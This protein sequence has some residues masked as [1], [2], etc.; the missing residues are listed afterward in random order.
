M[1]DQQPTVVA[2]RLGQVDRL[3]GGDRLLCGAADHVRPASLWATRY[4]RNRPDRHLRG[5]SQTADHSDR[6][7]L[8]TVTTSG[9]TAAILRNPTIGASP[10]ERITSGGLMMNQ[11]LAAASLISVFFALAQTGQE[12]AGLVGMASTVVCQT[13]IDVSNHMRMRNRR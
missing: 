6:H 12:A 5:S 11:R 1:H 13:A 8:R 10:A 3:P 4:R 2:S 9:S 7:S